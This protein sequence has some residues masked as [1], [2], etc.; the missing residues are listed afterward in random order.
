MQI[1]QKKRTV[2]IA[3]GGRALRGVTLTSL[4]DPLRNMHK[5]SFRGRHAPRTGSQCIK[6]YWPC[7]FRAGICAISMQ[8]CN[9]GPA[10]RDDWSHGCIHSV[11]EPVH[12]AS[13][14]RRRCLAHLTYNNT[15]NQDRCRLSSPSPRPSVGLGSLLAGPQTHWNSLGYHATT[16]FNK[17]KTNIVHLRPATVRSMSTFGAASQDR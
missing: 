8:V 13:I 10:R 16:P 7:L 2:A 11:R 17:V 1:R 6:L 5:P 3:R 4:A 15:R 9:I 12:A 14:G